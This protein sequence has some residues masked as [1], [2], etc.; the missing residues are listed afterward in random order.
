MA[1]PTEPRT[2][3]VESVVR[4]LRLL[5][6]FAPGEP[7][8]PLRE[9][10]RR[11]GY[12]K[13]TTYRLLRTLEG[14]GWLERTEDSEFKLTVKPFQV[15]SILIDDLELRREAGPI[16]SELAGKFSYT[17]YLIVPA[18]REAVCIE[19]VDGGLVRLL[20]LDVGGSMPYHLGAGP[21]VLLA[22][23]EAELMPLVKEEGL[24]RFTEETI[25]SMK[26]LKRDLAEVR[27]R[28]YSISRGDV[29]DG[30]AAIGAPVFDRTGEVVGAISMAGL[31]ESLEPPTEGE[32]AAAL[33]ERCATLSERMGYTGSHSAAPTIVKPR[34]G[35]RAP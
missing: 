34:S 31:L 27:E 5:E 11:G 30:V 4:A 21:R 28:G 16:V 18:R 10:V 12:S 32:I 17:T 9:L 20:F 7:Q 19:R 3:G 2:G 33:I 26:A 29:T 23:R 13:T 15:G 35:K 24:R 14:A 8:L 1:G 25:T 22:H 6:C